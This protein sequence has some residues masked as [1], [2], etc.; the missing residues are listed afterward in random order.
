MKMEV[1]SFEMAYSQL[2]NTNNPLA[3]PSNNIILHLIRGT[4]ESDV[5][6][7]LFRKITNDTFILF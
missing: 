6:Q 2:F 4:G 3:I 5:Q 7:A 1:I